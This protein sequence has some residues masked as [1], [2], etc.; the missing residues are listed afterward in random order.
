MLLDLTDI[1]AKIARAQEHRQ[2]IKDEIGAYFNRH[3]YGVTTQANA[4][5]TRYSI[6]FRVNE[7]PPLQRW[8]LMFADCLTNLR[9]ALDYLIYA[10]AC[11]E[12][13]PN[14]PRDSNYGFPITDSPENFGKALNVGRLGDISTTVRAAIERVQP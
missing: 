8:S 7:P 5:Y 10:I 6:L 13:A 1:R 4:D 11:H 12:A 2:A 14:P 3:P 9:T